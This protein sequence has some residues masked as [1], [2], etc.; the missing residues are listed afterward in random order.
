MTIGLRSAMWAAAFWSGGSFPAGE[1]VRMI[2]EKQL[3]AIEALTAAWLQLARPSGRID[4]MRLAAE[5]LR[6]Y[7]RRTRANARR[8]SR[9]R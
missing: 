7:R 9:S 5:V 6:P 2:G 3:A 4:H 8:L 1:A